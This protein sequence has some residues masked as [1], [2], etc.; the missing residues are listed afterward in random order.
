[1]FQKGNNSKNSK[2]TSD[3]AF[4][5]PMTQINSDT[6]TSLNRFSPLQNYELRKSKEDYNENTTT[7]FECNS[8]T[9]STVKRKSPNK[10][11]PVVINQFPENQADF[12]RFCTVPSKK[13]YSNA[14]KTRYNGDIK[15]FSDSIPRGIRMRD[16]NKFI[17][18]GKTKLQCFPG[19]T[20]N[21]L[22]HYLYV[23]FQDNNRESVILHVGVNDSLQDST[24]TNI[25]GFFQ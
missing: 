3:N 19:A 15:I 2:L 14:M 23:T 4:N 13:P 6:I 16:F 12:T 18:V 10:R 1:M 8:S 20:S 11:P 7:N 24:E 25:N 9:N 22:L 17:K 21:Q 5:H